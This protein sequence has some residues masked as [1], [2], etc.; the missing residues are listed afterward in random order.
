M[1]FDRF[2]PDRF[3]TMNNDVGM[4]LTE[5]GSDYF[6]D[7]GVPTSWREGTNPIIP[8]TNQNNGDIEP[9]QG[10][11]KIITSAGYYFDTKVAST[12]DAGVNWAIPTVVPSGT[13][14]AYTEY[15]L[16][17]KFHTSNPDIIYAGNKISTD[18]G[19]TFQALSFLDNMNGSIFG[20]CDKF[21]DVIYAINRNTSRDKIYRSTDHGQ[22]WNIYA[23]PGYSFTPLDSRP[24]F[25]VHPTDPN[26]V[27]AVCNGNMGGITRGDMAVFDGISWKGLEVIDLAG[28]TEY[29]NFVSKIAFDPRFP[30]IM[31]VSMFTFG[32]ENIWRSIDDGKTWM[33][34][35][36]NLPR[37]G[38]NGLQVNPHTGE[39]F[40][41]SAA[42]TWIFPPP[43]KSDSA[44]YNKN[45]TRPYYYALPSCYTGKIKDQQSNI[46]RDNLLVKIYNTSDQQ[47]LGEGITKDGYFFIPVPTD[48]QTT[49]EDEGTPDHS[50]ILVKLFKDGVEYQLYTDSLGTQTSITH[51]SGV[52]KEIN[53]WIKGAALGFQ[54]R[55]NLSAPGTLNIYPN[56]FSS[57][58]KIEY[59]ITKKTRV[60]IVIYN[61]QGKEVKKLLDRQQ[62]P[63]MYEAI[64]DG[65]DNGNNP[66]SEG[67][68]ICHMRAESFNYEQ[69]MLLIK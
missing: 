46:P 14:T 22:N 44:I 2:N 29:G 15:H 54:E 49:L 33:D 4:M 47:L 3:V 68:Y 31:Y 61:F 32:I 58:T 63:G 60:Y 69:K 9:V 55:I 52:N 10:S 38:A 27:Y 19:L 48:D 28:G 8:W 5:T 35:S 6:E 66:V 7:R 41:G 51:E 34:I 56:P 20:M 21:P 43:Y 16:F 42:G 36:Y 11:K 24:I 67:L 30:N 13:T 37:M 26:K 57:A 39:L 17:V 25:N 40:I 18:G 64:W 12:I 23:N 45:Y 59:E 62:Q 65:T 50:D 53:L 1:V